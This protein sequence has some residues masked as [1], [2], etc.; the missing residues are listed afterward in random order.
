MP[1]YR[2]RL[3]KTVGGLGN[4]ESD[5]LITMEIMCLLAGGV[6]YGGRIL[7]SKI[8]LGD[9]ASET[10]CLDQ[11]A[12]RRRQPLLY[13]WLTGWNYIRSSAVQGPPHCRHTLEH[14]PTFS[15]NRSVHVLVHAISMAVYRMMCLVAGSDLQSGEPVPT[16]SLAVCCRI[17]ECCGAGFDNFACPWPHPR[18]STKMATICMSSRQLA[19]ARGALWDTGIQLRIG[20]LGLGLYC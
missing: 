4:C 17:L 15:G 11:I 19:G 8:Y 18:T 7:C 13:M 14:I 3:L 5:A 20:Y 9:L 6:G 2:G 16:T 10:F 12:T 1:K